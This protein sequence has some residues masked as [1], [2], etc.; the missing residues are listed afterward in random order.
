[1]KQFADLF[2]QLDQTTKTNEKV[3]ALAQYFEASS[4]PDKVWA[5]ALLG[6]KRPKR[7]LSAARLREWAAWSAGIPEWLFEQSYHVVGDLAETIALLLPAPERNSDRTLDEWMRGMVSLR[8]ESDLVKQRFVFEAWNELNG[9]E[10]FAFN[11]LITGGFRMGVSQKLM[12][13]ALARFLEEDESIVAHRLM[14]DWDPTKITFESL[15]VASSGDENQSRPYPF[16]LAYPLEEEPEELGSVSDWQIEHKW[17]GIRGQVISRGGELYIWSR[18]E[19]LVTEKFPELSE[20]ATCLPSGTVIDGEILAFSDGQPLNFQV[21]QTRIGRKNVTAKIQ[22]QAPV[23]ILAYDLLEW[24]GVDIREKPLRERRVQLEQVVHQANHDRLRLSPTVTL[25]SWSALRAERARAREVH[26]EGLMLKRSS[27]SYQVGRKRGGWWK[28]KVDP[29]T[30]DAVLIYAMRG[31][32]RR[33]NLY[34]DYTFAVWN[35][36][37]LVPF[38]KAYSGLTDSEFR[39]VDAFVKKNTLERFGPVRSVRPELVFEIAFEGIARSTRHK[40]GV[41]LRF[42]RMHRWRTD[43][44]VE[45]ANTLEDLEKLLEQYG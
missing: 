42:P 20:F 6:G 34:T 1:M 19:E 14:G 30:I 11:K 17:D 9:T 3:R 18:G 41:A 2:Q 31:H 10:R 40:S 26:S 28:W 7:T 24:Q 8:E 15:A 27:S 4:D 21:L 36:E 35:G 38:T 39:Q 43:K 25:D 16:F 45:E 37:V 22:Q 12:T 29:L 5:I 33:A 32:G 13:R 44:P 23:A